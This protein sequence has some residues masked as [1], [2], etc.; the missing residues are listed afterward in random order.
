VQPAP[1]RSPFGGA[2]G[3]EVPSHIE[4]TATLS[5]E[6]RRTDSPLAELGVPPNRQR[7]EFDERNLIHPI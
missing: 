4:T 3:A 6:P 5:S 2:S 7:S 1:K